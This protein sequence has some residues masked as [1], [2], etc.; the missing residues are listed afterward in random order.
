MYKVGTLNEN[1][2]YPNYHT[3]L[4]HK[5]HRCTRVGVRSFVSFGDSFLGGYL[6]FEFC[7]CRTASFSLLFF[8]ED[9]LCSQFS[10]SHTPVA[11]SF[12]FC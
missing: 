5:F 7:L 12:T 1:R 9:C 11:L 4:T 3:Y 10:V 2:P 8:F 6:F